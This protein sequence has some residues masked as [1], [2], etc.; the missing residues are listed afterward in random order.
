[1]SRV[2]HS[3]CPFPLTNPAFDVSNISETINLTSWY[4]WVLVL[5]VQKGQYKHNNNGFHAI[6][7]SRV[8]G[9]STPSAI[10]SM[11]KCGGEY[12]GKFHELTVFRKRHSTCVRTMPASTVAMYKGDS[13]CHQVPGFTCR[14]DMRKAHRGFL[15]G[16][17]VPW[18]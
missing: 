17:D 9:N 12:S 13:T 18:T 6:S 3:F 7:L 10:K 4:L 2:L 5:W 8:Y 1:M 15:T 14:I 11:E 16:F